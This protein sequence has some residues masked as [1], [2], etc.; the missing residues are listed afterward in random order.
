MRRIMACVLGL[1][2]FA[3]APA[4]AF[5]DSATEDTQTEDI[6]VA[7]EGDNTYEGSGSADSADTKASPS[8]GSSKTAATG[9]G[10]SPLVPACLAVAASTVA[11]A[12]RRRCGNDGEWR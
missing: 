3:C 11:F 5:A 6:E 8:S 4:V 10:V 9:D 7:V 12:A 1:M 2:L